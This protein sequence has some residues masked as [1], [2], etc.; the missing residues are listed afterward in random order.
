[1]TAKNPPDSTALT[2]NAIN[3]QKLPKDIKIFLPN[4]PIFPK[5][6][7]WQIWGAYI[8][9]S[10]LIGRRSL[11][12]S[13]FIVYCSS[14]TIHRSSSIIHRSSRETHEHRGV[15]GGVRHQSYKPS[16]VPSQMAVRKSFF[17][18]GF[19]QGFAKCFIGG[20]KD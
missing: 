7:K 6:Q 12:S 16:W 15:A 19:A 9:Q 5:I 10:S 4:F 2:E 3:W 8:H 11:F 18:E 1:M 13:S 20:L 17:A 14:S